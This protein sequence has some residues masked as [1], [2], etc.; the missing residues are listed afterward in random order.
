MNVNKSTSEVSSL[1]VLIC[2]DYRFT[3]YILKNYI[4]SL[5]QQ[6]WIA[7][8]NG[9]NKAS[10][11]YFFLFDCTC[12]SKQPTKITPNCCSLPLMTKYECVSL[13]PAWDLQ[14]GLPAPWQ[15]GRRMV[16][17]PRIAGHAAILNP[18]QAT[19]LHLHHRLLPP[20][21]TDGRVT[22]MWAE[23]DR[24]KQGTTLSQS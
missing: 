14:P 23:W 3:L 2:F 21:A 5:K 7:G 13:R 12:G 17:I 24:T 4:I 1:K 8:S 11:I 10:S 15:G 20:A 19:R 6:G 16:E 22:T 18:N 9:C